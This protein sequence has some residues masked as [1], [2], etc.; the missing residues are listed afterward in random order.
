MSFMKKEEQAYVCAR[1]NLGRTCTAQPGEDYSWERTL[2]K[3]LC[4]CSW[5]CGWVHIRAR[6]TEGLRTRHFVTEKTVHHSHWTTIPLPASISSSD[7]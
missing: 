3:H 2:E 6:M 4:L 7:P 5:N 1:H